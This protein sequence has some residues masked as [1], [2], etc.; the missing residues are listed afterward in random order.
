MSWNWTQPTIHIPQKQAVQ[1]V[2]DDPSPE[3]IALFCR[4]FRMMNGDQEPD[5][6]GTLADVWRWLTGKCA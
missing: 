5:P 6:N 4:T 1:A 3:K 2:S